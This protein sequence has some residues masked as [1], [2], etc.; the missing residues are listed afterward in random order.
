GMATGSVDEI[1]LH[2]LDLQTLADTRLQASGT[3][4]GILEIKQPFLDLNI[5]RLYTTSTDIRTLVPDTVLSDSIAIPPWLNVNARWKGSADH[6]RFNT[7]ISTPYGNVVANGN[8]NIDSSANNPGYSMHA[9]I[10]DF[11]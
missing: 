4:A 11:N 3:I 9:V 6:A 7:F 2:Q 5:Q 10:N 8:I 1:H